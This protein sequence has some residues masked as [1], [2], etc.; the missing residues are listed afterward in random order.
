MHSE[1][2]LHVPDICQKDPCQNIARALVGT[3]S[4]LGDSDFVCL[5]QATNKWDDESNSCVFGE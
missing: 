3:C 4:P 2:E 1:K 5:C